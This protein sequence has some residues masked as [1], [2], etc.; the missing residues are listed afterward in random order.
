MMPPLNRH[1]EAA[2]RVKLGGVEGHAAIMVSIS[3][4][5][6]TGAIVVRITGMDITRRQS[7]LSWP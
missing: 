2:D 5:T 4:R 3:D 1:L 7:K 6:M